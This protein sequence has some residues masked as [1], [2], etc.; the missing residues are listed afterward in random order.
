MKSRIKKLLAAALALCLIAAL[1]P[2]AALAAD[3]PQNFSTVTS[4]NVSQKS[5]FATL[6]A[7][8][9]AI[10]DFSPANV[11]KRQIWNS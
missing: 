7:A 6:D 11:Y 9:D 2:G 10:N 4:G 1:V 3:T 5:Y 8:M